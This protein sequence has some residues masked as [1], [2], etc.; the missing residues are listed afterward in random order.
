MLD[1]DV[2]KNSVFYM[3]KMVPYLQH[4]EVSNEG[5]DKLILLIGDSHNTKITHRFQQ[6]YK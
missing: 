3:E 2:D 5:Q 1:K 6:L 4:Y